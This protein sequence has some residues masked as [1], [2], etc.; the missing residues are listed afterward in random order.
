MP[1]TLT[2][3][4]F[5]QLSPDANLT[6]IA[7]EEQDFLKVFDARAELMNWSTVW[8]RDRL[9]LLWGTYEAE[10]TAGIDASRI[11]WVYVEL[12]NLVD[13]NKAMPELVDLPRLSER[14]PIPEGAIAGWAAIS[15]EDVRKFNVATVKIAVALPALV[16]CFDDALRRFGAVELSGLQVTC[17]N[18]DLDTGVGPRG[19]HLAYAPNWFDIVSQQAR[20]DAIIAFDQ[21][22]LGG[23]TEAEMVASLRRRSTG[24]L[25]FGPVVAVPEQYS[26]EVEEQPFRSISPAH[27]GLGVSVTLPE[28]TASAAGWVLAKVVNAAR[29][30]SPDVRNF[31]VR[32]TRVQ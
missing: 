25:E 13:L 9:P 11:G 27:S 3:E 12:S 7:F 19:G 2:L 23:H 15:D 22:F 30:F 32:I 17:H 16:Q 10:L 24:S 28:W 26:I 1:P 21:G 29:D 5:G 8:S 18:A 20:A 31:A 6:G 4:A 14:P